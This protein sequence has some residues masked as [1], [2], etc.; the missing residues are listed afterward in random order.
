MSLEPNKPLRCKS[1]VTFIYGPGSLS[2]SLSLPS[3]PPLSPP[4]SL[5]LPLPS[6]PPLSLSLTLSLSHSLTL[7]SPSLI[8]KKKEKKARLS[9]FCHF[10]P[11]GRDR[12]K[13]IARLIA[14][15]LHFKPWQGKKPTGKQHAP[16]LFCFVLATAP[17]TLERNQTWT[18]KAL[19]NRTTEKTGA[20]DWSTCKKLPLFLLF[21]KSTIW[22]TAVKDGLRAFFFPNFLLH[23]HWHDFVC[24]CSLR[25][26]NCCQ[27]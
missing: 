10:P 9:S 3:P 17:D 23:E 2:L 22:A 26:F 12:W 18:V 25:V 7:S 1:G 21:M 11:V 16:V 4:L 27:R 5:S 15:I 24:P 19:H 13:E 6:L 14:A 8:K 20:A